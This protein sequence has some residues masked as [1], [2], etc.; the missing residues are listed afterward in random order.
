M[1]YNDENCLDPTIFRSLIDDIYDEIVI[2]DHNSNLLY[3]NKACYRHYGLRPEDMIGKNI[4]ELSMKEKYWGPTTL[5]YVQKEKK[6]AMQKQR[7]LLGTNIVTISIPILDEEGN[8]KYILQSVRDDDDALAMKLAPIEGAGAIPPTG[9]N[10]R[11]LHRSEC[12]GKT[13]EYAKKISGAEAP[14]LI[15]GETGTG[16]SLLARFIHDS[17]KRKEKPFVTINMAS[18][19]PT[20]IESELFGYRKGAFTGANAGGKKGLFEMANGGTLFLDEI[21]EL[22]YSLQ[23]KFLHVIQEKEYIPIGGTNPV[24]TDFV[25][26]AATNCDLK[27]MIDAGRFREDLYH[28]LSVFEITIPPLRE[29]LEDLHLLTSYF[30]NVFNKKYSKNSYF[31]DE[32]LDVINNYPWKG[33]VRELS[34]VIERSVLTAEGN[35][36]RPNDLPNRLFK[37]NDLS[38]RNSPLKNSDGMVS[39]KKAMENCEKEIVLEA[40]K[41]HNSSRKV[42]KELGISQTKACKLISKYITT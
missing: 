34:N 29:R 24:P 33:N 31:S 12:M 4:E 14:C 28:R 11:I 32:A 42:A 13:L 1:S 23:A 39:L 36:I 2:W 40:Y 41:K 10:G 25:I 26:I 9:E 6:A 3:I 27:K 17:S 7:T 16:K 5:P 37:M 22:P 35:R 19:N 38:T 18:M 30:L 21:G 8:I 20:I 15:L